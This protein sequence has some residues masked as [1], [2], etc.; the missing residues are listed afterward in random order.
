MNPSS[1]LNSLA[2]GKSVAAADPRIMQLAL[3]YVF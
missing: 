3:K 2:F 1:A